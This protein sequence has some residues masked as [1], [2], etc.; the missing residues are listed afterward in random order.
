M[1]RIPTGRGTASF[2]QHRDGNVTIAVLMAI[3]DPVAPTAAVDG[4][5]ALLG[6]Q[7]TD[8]LRLQL[9]A[10]ELAE[11][12]QHLRDSLRPRIHQRDGQP[13]RHFQNRIEP[14]TDRKRP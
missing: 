14:G 13:A 2:R 4:L 9:E 12:N 6:R 5:L 1:Q 11:E 7:L 8:R 3:H 10:S